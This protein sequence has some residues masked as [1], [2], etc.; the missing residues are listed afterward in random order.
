MRLGRSTANVLLLMSLLL[1]LAIIYLYIRSFLIGDIAS[2]SS[3][4]NGDFE[5]ESANGSIG[6]YHV[7][8]AAPGA[9]RSPIQQGWSYFP[10]FDN[11]SAHWWQN[12]GASLVTPSHVYRYFRASQRHGFSFPHWVAEVLDLAI[13]L[14]CL[15]V[16]AAY[17]K[18]VKAGPTCQ[19]CGYDLR[20]TPD[21]CPECGTEAHL[22]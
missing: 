14:Y 6:I 1:S 9:P 12:I 22:A 2:F 5:F 8:A 21:R 16:R 10:A 19:K 20:A 3:R 18:L 11:S 7:T 4:A 13:V 17:S 15:Q